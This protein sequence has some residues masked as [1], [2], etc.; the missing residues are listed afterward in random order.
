MRLASSDVGLF[1]QKSESDSIFSYKN[2]LQIWYSKNSYTEKSEN[3]FFCYPINKKTKER[4]IVMKKKI[5]GI[6]ASLTFAVD[7]SLF[8]PHL[9]Q[10]AQ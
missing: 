6:T 10:M 1:S 9:G 7:C 2:S 3:I 4:K 8:S 5:W